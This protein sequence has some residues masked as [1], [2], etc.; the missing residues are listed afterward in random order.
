MSYDTVGLDF[1]FDFDHSAATC[2]ASFVVEEGSDYFSPEI[3]LFLN[4]EMEINE[5]TVDRSPWQ[6]SEELVSP[7]DQEGFLLKRILIK[8]LSVDEG[9]ISLSIGYHGKL[10]GF[11]AFCP[12]VHDRIAVDFTMVRFQSFLFPFLAGPRETEY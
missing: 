6:H 1:A 10:D 8:D 12:Y 9:P 5:V 2:V 7:L 4:P 3:A 11:E